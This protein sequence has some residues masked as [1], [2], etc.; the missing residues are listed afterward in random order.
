[1]L[2]EELSTLVNALNQMEQSASFA[3][4]YGPYF[5]AV[6]LLVIA[7]FICRTVFAGSLGGKDPVL[8]KRASE[9]F[10]FYFRSTVMVGIVCVLA[11]VGWWLYENYREDAR[12]V[13][14]V[15]ELKA[16]LEKFEAL[17][18]SMNFAAYGIVSDGIK[19]QDIFYANLINPQISVVF[20]KLPANILNS[21]AS[22]FF[23]VLSNQEL[24]SALDISVGWSQHGD[25]PEP[26]S[27]LN[28]PMR[29]L[30]AKKYGLYKFSLGQDAA[31]IQPISN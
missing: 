21:E 3:E 5:F 28:M 20:A 13:A 18:K 23:V 9:D 8:R 10:R 2:K 22:W 27:I 6:A 4:K 26:A 17:T 12:T 15:A 14:T 31:T 1:M 16:K 30:L 19:A 25:G 29:L 24:P 11:G 7:P